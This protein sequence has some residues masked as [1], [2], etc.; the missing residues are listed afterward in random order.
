MMEQVN[1]W[2]R[3]FQRRTIVYVNAH[4]LNLASRDAVYRQILNQADIIYPDGIAVVWACRF[5]SGL[6]LQKITGR[7]WIVDFCEQAIAHQLGVYI[8]AGKPGVARRAAEKMLHR[9][10]TL[11]ICGCADGFFAEKS[12]GDI[13][14]EIAISQPRVVFVGMG[15]PA[16]EKWVNAH[17]DE[18]NAP[19]VWAVG[20]LFDY[21]A[22]MER[23][24][25]PL[26][27]TLA[28]EWLWRLIMDPRGKWRRYVIGNPLFVAR[29]L[30]Q[31]L[32]RPPS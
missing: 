16:Q 31:K 5:L 6:R 11:R 2:A 24:V 14:Q 4:C 19:V 23:P 13:F 20:A 15:T 17:R 28:L 1:E 32:M 26:L 12:E 9:W 29:V 25:P 10:P 8:L 3:Q 7:E 27:N 18:I 22:G 21:I 30:R